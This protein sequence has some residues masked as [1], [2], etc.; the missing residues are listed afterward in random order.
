MDHVNEYKIDDAIE[1]IAETPGRQRV[2]NLSLA[3]AVSATVLVM[4]G[5]LAGWLGHRADD[6]QHAQAQRDQLIATAKQSALNL[7]TIDHTKVEAEVQRIL[8]SSVGTFHDD[9]QQR[10]QSLIDV[11]KR[12][13]STSEG[14]ITGAALESQDGDQAQVLVAV[15][16]KTSTPGTP[17]QDTRKWRMRITVHNVGDG[18][19]VSNVQFLP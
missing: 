9:F 11:V 13:R 6:A 14:T 16:V 19:H 1:G 2:S 8:D 17:D 18:T 10:S 3:T 4:L 12:A 7:T 15:S 5:C